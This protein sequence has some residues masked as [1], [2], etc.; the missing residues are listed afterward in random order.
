M[1]FI[2]GFFINCKNLKLETTFFDFRLNYE[3]DKKITLSKFGN[4][5]LLLKWAVISR[6]KLNTQHN[7][8]YKW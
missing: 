4:Q 5:I 7:V 2:F 6:I 3:N 8:T 1:N